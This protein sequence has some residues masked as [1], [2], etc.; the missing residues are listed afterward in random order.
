MNF[1]LNNNL[2]AKIRDR[3]GEVRKVRIIDNLSLRASH[4]LQ[5]DS[6]RWSDIS[7]SGFTTIAGR[8]PVNVGFTHSL[9]DRD[10]TGAT[11]D[12]YLW[13][14]GKPALRLKRMNASVNGNWSGQGE[15]PWSIRAGYTMRLQRN[16]RQDLQADTTILSQ[17][18]TFNGDVTLFEDWRL[19][20]GSGYDFTQGTSRIRRSICGGTC[21]AGN[22]RRGGCRS[23]SS[24]ACSCALRSNRRCCAM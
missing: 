8:F 10:T 4:N 17:N 22:S 20:V 18:L 14:E 2:E 6:I 21:I 12:R 11:I 19:T 23:A 7:G 13:E 1:T 16:W 15:V 5:A 3:E 9:Y 24:R